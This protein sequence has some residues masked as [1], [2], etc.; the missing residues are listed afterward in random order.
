MNNCHPPGLAISHCNG[1]LDFKHRATC[2][3]FPLF[4]M[5]CLI[6]MYIFPPVVEL[7][8]KSSLLDGPS[9]VREGDQ[10]DHTNR[11]ATF[12][13]VS[14]TLIRM[15]SGLCPR[16]DDPPAPTIAQGPSLFIL[17][18]RRLL[19]RNKPHAYQQRAVCCIG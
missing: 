10:L 16:P 4:S 1:S 7:T 12:Q 5:P 14:P 8:F 6:I 15:P 9:S 18:A 2:S 11:E 3:V 13:F 19:V 17:R